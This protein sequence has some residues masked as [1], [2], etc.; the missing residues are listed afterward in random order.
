MIDRRIVKFLKKH[1]VLTIATSVDN[2]PWCA[3]CFYVFL[4][5]ENALVFTS[6]LTTRHGREFLMNNL[7]AGTVALETMITG[8]IRGVQFEGT[9][10]E[11][12]PDLED[13]TRNAY[14]KKFPVAMLMETHLWILRLTHI[15]YTDNRLGFG[16][17]LIWKAE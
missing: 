12:G 10:A 1:H 15:K 4:E 2:K 6:D 17:K 5:K 14:L 13:I 16:K 7:V 9:V 3:S 8:M 11:P